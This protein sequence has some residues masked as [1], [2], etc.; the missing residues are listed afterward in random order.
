METYCTDHIV[1]NNIKYEHWSTE[2]CAQ[3]TFQT[4]KT[5]PTYLVLGTVL[6]TRDIR[7][8]ILIYIF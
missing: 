2:N 1:H 4:Q 5:V 6:Y 7:Y 3:E 8:Y